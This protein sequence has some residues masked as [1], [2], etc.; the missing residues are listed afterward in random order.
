MNISFAEHGDYNSEIVA[1]QYPDDAGKHELSSVQK[2]QLAI[3]A[4]NADVLSSM[5]YAKLT[6]DVRNNL[7]EAEDIE[8]YFSS[9]TSLRPNHEWLR[10]DFS[11]DD[12]TL[13]TYTIKREK[14]AAI[15]ELLKYGLDVDKNEKALRPYL[16]LRTKETIILWPC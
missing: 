13:L 16:R 3:L 5:S 6:G 4:A 11:W 9:P 15:R 10:D 12:E 8:E 1:A 2:Q 14:E 7:P